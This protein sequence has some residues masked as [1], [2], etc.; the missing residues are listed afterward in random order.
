MS[1]TMK[2][3]QNNFKIPLWIFFALAL[4]VLMGYGIRNFTSGRP[5]FKFTTRVSKLDQ[6]LNY[7]NEHYVDSVDVKEIEE[8]AIISALTE[9]DP[10]S[11]YLSSVIATRENE[12]MEGEYEGVGIEFL[13]VDDTIQVV[14]ALSGGPSKEV[15]IYAGD[16]IITVN[17]STVAGVDITTSKVIEILKGPE[18]T[19]VDVGIKRGDKEELLDF[20]ITRAPIPLNSIDVAYMISEDVGYIKINRFSLKTSKEYKIHLNKL[21]N[22]GMESLII[23]LRGN[24]GGIMQDA[25]EVLDEI[26]GGNKLLLSAEGRNYKRTEYQA[27]LDGMFEQGRL[28]ILIDEGSASASEI[29]AGAVQDWDRGVLI[30]RR[31]FGKGLVQQSYNLRGG[32]E[33]RLTVARYYTPSGRSI[34]RS[35][36]NGVEDYYS[37]YYHRLDSGELISKDSIKVDSSLIKYTLLNERPV[38]G[39]GG[40]IPDVFVPVDTSSTTD[41]ITKVFSER[42]PSE[43]VYQYFSENRSQLENY[44]SAGEFEDKFLF[45]T[46]L[47]N[48]F[49]EFATSRLPEETLS[50]NNISKSKAELSVYIKAII[51]RQLFG[52]EGFYVVMNDSDDAILKALSVLHSDTYNSLLKNSTTE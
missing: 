10:H 36:K 18:G 12:Q 16:K 17:D 48:R 15:G 19:S 44:K 35:Y 11:V 46:T 4:G 9:L 33:L 20:T 1:D 38:Y 5:T 34:Q 28:A 39:G 49:V 29:V 43:F 51:A 37:D 40:I 25:L 8:N 45:G 47:Y 22:A 50:A 41:F 3:E 23:D 52:N 31:T 21:V 32:S 26:I 6:V 27:L 42:L 7:V 2:K 24:G 30:G 14:S 13:I